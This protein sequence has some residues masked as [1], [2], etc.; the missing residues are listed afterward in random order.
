MAGSTYILSPIPQG[1][2]VAT[3][4]IIRGVA[5]LGMLMMTIQSFAMPEVASINPTTFERLSGNDLYVWIVS[6]VFADQKF[7]GIFSML[8]GASIVMLSQKARKEHL[9][10]TDLQYKRFVYLGIFGLVHAY[11]LYYGDVLLMYAICGLLM[12]IF[13]SKK[14]STQLRAGILL[15]AIGSAISLLL[16]YSV[17]LWEPGEYEIRRA[18]IWNPPSS[19]LAEEIEGYHSN[20]ERQIL[21]RAPQAFATQTTGFIF[22]YFWRIAGMMLLGMAL[23]KRRVFKGKQSKKYYVKMVVYGIGIGLPLV[24]A[25]VFLNFQYNWDFRISY[26]FT[27]QLN[28][29]G[30]V[31]MSIGYVG[32]IVLFCKAGTR[33]FLAKRL[34][35]VGRMSLSNYLFQSIICGIIFYGH[36]F[37]LFGDL[38]R[39]AQAVFVL[40]IWVVN[41]AFS[42]IWLKYFW[43]GPFEW[44]WRSL[45]YGKVQPL[46]K[47]LS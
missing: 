9:R 3:L 28:Y 19:V 4:D 38:D 1:K 26:F 10:S 31:L 6:H 25:G 40:A 7:L 36:G 35:D 39:S 2:R 24:V 34:A 14:T 29:W 11:L 37:N 20:W 30:S 32:I 21:T 13:R 23:Y 12:F 41:I 27:S 18:E 44:L 17:E 47:V 8:F 15:L 22:H 16:G 43:F 46:A 42:G 5:V 45:T 33:S